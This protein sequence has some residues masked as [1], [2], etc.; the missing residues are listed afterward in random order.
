M[1]TIYHDF[2]SL[3]TSVII[4]LFR[5]TYEEFYDASISYFYLVLSNHLR[6]IALSRLIIYITRFMAIRYFLSKTSR[7]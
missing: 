2:A 1:T 3:G 6:I 7:I 5:K 4:P